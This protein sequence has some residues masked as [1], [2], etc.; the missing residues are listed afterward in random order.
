MELGLGHWMMAAD[1]L[2][3]LTVNEYL[4]KLDGYMEA[5]GFNAPERMTASRLDELKQLYPD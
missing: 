5:N 3:R 2:W 1:D 4:A